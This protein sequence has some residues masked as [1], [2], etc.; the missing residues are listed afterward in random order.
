[1][2]KLQAHNELW[3]DDHHRSWCD[4]TY[5]ALGKPD[6]AYEKVRAPSANSVQ[7]V[8]TERQIRLFRQPLRFMRGPSHLNER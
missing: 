6:E 5:G 1:M 2:A 7:H 8:V 3:K 4:P